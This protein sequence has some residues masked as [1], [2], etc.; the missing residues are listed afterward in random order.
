MEEDIRHVV[1]SVANLDTEH[2]N[3]VKDSIGIS[4]D[5]KKFYTKFSAESTCI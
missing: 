5:G 4:T 1:R 3:P 2:K